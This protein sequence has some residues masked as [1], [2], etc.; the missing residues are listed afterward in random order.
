VDAHTGEIAFQASALRRSLR[1]LVEAVKIAEGT[2]QKRGLQLC[3]YL[4]KALDAIAKRIAALEL[5][6]AAS[7]AATE[8]AA[9]IREVRLLNAAVRGLHDSVP[10]LGSLRAPTLSLGLIYFLDEA[11]AALLRGRADLILNAGASY[12]Y[13][14][15]ALERSF[16]ILLSK[17]GEE[18]PAG[19]APLVITY[20]KLEEERVL[21]HPV[22]VH[23]LGHDAVNHHDLRDQVF[24]RATNLDHL[25]RQF[26]EAVKSF[27]QFQRDTGAEPVSQEECALML[28]RLL[29][30]W[31]EELLCDHVALA[32]LGPSY[33]FAATAFLL[34]VSSAQPSDTH[35]ASHARIRMLLQFVRVLDW[36]RLL[37]ARVPGIMRWL[38]AVSEEPLPAEVPGFLRFVDDAMD[39]LAIP[40]RETV[41]EHLRDEV[42][43]PVSYENVSEELKDLLGN[44]V[45]PAQLSS[46]EPADRRA[47]LLAG[48]LHSIEQRGDRPES[49]PGAL[50]NLDIQR[51]LAKALE[52][53]FIL[54]RW[55]SV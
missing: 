45:L 10:W 3:A 31:L 40:M 28:R 50:E 5:Q 32:Y 20:P 46:S 9:I 1:D 47:I 26:E 39:L 34:P 44:E 41:T 22:L 49:I 6:F 33:L 4:R 7:A 43:R 12:M 37:E 27:E 36:H 21:L 55:R 11:A 51:F 2:E 23:E 30:A 19:P 48:W 25:N 14:T 53:S 52:M 29:T 35:P 15:M 18:V 54:E 16:A 38:N 24:K 13:S 17:L 8:Q 42:F